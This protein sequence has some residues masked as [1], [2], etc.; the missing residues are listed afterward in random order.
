MVL[1]FACLNGAD[2][3]SKLQLII[4]AFCDL[5]P[6]EKFIIALNII[7]F[8]KRAYKIGCLSVKRFFFPGKYL[9]YGIL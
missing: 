2:P 8:F 5:K 9:L 3:R 7:F 6:F 4:F 1:L